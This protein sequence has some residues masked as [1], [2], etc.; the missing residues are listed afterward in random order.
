MEQKISP[1]NQKTSQY[2]TEVLSRYGRDL[3]ALA[4]L[5]KLDPVIGRD[6][7]I[8]R[9][10]EVLSRRTKN[11]PVLIGEPGVGKTAIAEGLALR[12]F[13]K[14]TPEI[15]WSKKVIAL[16]IASMVAGA[17]FQG[18]FENRLKAFV[19]EVCDS[20]GEVILFIDELHTLVGA[21]KNQGSMD[22]AQILK[23]ALA[24]GELRA[25]GATTLDEYRNFI[26]KDKALERRF[27]VVKVCE[28]DIPSTLTILRGLKEKY[29]N[30][31]GVRIKDQALV[32]AA[33]LSA[34]YIND[35]FLPDKAID[36]MDEASSR[37]SIEIQGVPAEIDEME[38]T[39]THLQVEGKALGKE[40][41]SS[42][43]T[44][45]KEVK[46]EIKDLEQKLGVLKN[47]WKKEK[48]KISAIRKIK[49]DMEAQK[50]KSSRLEREGR[51]DEVAEIKYSTLPALQK[52]LKFYEKNTPLSAVST[53]QNKKLTPVVDEA[54]SLLKE[55][56]GQEE[57]AQAVFRWTGIPVHKMLQSEAD[58]LL[59][60]EQKLGEKVVGQPQALQVVSESLR[61]SRAGLSDPSSPIG[62]FLFLGPTGV[63]KTQTAKALAEFLFDS[64]EQ[65]FRMDMSEYTEKHHVSRLIGAPPGYIGYE[66]GG[67]LTEAVRRKPYSIVLLDEIEKA[68]PEVF[69]LLLQVMDAGHLTCSQGRRVN[70]KNTILIMTSNI[71]SSVLR[72]SSLSESQKREKTSRELKKCFQPEFLNRLDSIVSFKPLKPE[73]IFDIVKIQIKDIQKRLSGKHITLQ[74]ED[75]AL[76]FLAR[77]AF[78]PDYG[79][80][81]VQRVLQKELLNPLACDLI[82]QKIREN[83]SV[84][85]TGG[86]LKLHFKLQR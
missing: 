51:L 80:R 28:P 41:D 40:S 8:R 45:L 60:L 32:A 29:E 23:P 52:K 16:D 34:R 12:I 59:H 10:I 55:E 50:L 31:H 37:L 1:L 11:N 78:D 64:P 21:G 22:A 83:T 86:D 9:V 20:Q 66:Q 76:K 62:S 58:K 68:H 35:R 54:P 14:D 65:I 81:P 17:S 3:T 19:R 79:A 2:K 42:S 46:K 57:I 47:R 70:F 75:K 6:T 39:L 36:L 30:Y 25:I 44:R 63:G 24:R 53:V 82:S 56:V 73:H 38:R 71:S 61:R 67:E 43:Q 26:E 5:G 72:D 74:V 49:K 48:E 15:L 4:E 7:E 13:N 77:R 27:Q 33:E 69:H 18:A 84:F 85:V